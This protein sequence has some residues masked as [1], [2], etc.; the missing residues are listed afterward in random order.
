MNLLLLLCIISSL[1]P[2]S[3]LLTQVIFKKCQVN[4]QYTYNRD[5]LLKWFWIFLW[6][7]FFLMENWGGNI[8]TPHLVC[9]EIIPM[10]CLP[11]LCIWMFIYLPW[12][13]AV[14]WVSV[15]CG[16]SYMIGEFLLEWLYRI[17]SRR[18]QLRAVYF[19][20]CLLQFG[21]RKLHNAFST[22]VICG[23]FC[24]FMGYAWFE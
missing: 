22:L 16:S 8:I 19:C 2:D 13:F 17:W 4:K 18:R 3:M 7:F 21:T 15:I 14:F 5:N 12:L 9:E 10:I 1:K 20:S 6:F 23:S 11:S 24:D